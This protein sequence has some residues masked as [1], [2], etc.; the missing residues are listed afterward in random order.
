M[1]FEHAQLYPLDITVIEAA[2]AKQAFEVEVNRMIQEFRRKTGLHV[3]AIE[4]IDCRSLIGD[5]DF[6]AQARVEML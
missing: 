3:T 1:A 2:K 5:G 4:L 6:M